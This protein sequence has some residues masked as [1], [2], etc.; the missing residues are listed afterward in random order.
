MNCYTKYCENEAIAGSIFCADCSEFPKSALQPEEIEKIA[1]DVLNNTFKKVIKNLTNDFYNS[2]SGFLYEH[3]DNYQD[4]VMKEAMDLIIGKK[5]ARYRDN[6]NLKELRV[7]IYK[8]HKE[9]FDKRITEQVID[10]EIKRYF[11]LFLT[12]EDETGWRY[13]DLENKIVEW[14]CDNYKKSKKLKQLVP[15]GLTKRNE[16]LQR[17]IIS[18]QNRLNEIQEL[19]G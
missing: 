16:I 17:K 5:W 7:R 15:K 12:D 1:E 14:I 2:L 13:V 3:T 8:E 11:N 9:E 10:T 18:L 6:Y 19:V 4:T